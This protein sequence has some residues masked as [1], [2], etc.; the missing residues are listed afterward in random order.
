MGVRHFSL[1]TDLSVL[2]GWWRKNGDEL[3]KV[4]SDA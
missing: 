2:Y 3:R 4:I 1:G